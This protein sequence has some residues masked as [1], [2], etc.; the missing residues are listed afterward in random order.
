[1]R[2][3]KFSQDALTELEIETTKRALIKLLEQ[4]VLKL[5]DEVGRCW[6][7]IVDD[8]GLYEFDKRER[9]IEALEKVTKE[10][11]I[12]AFNKLIFE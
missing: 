3:N 12:T 5:G 10:Q 9:K 4:K 8:T 6:D 7:V 1:M 11:V 2:V